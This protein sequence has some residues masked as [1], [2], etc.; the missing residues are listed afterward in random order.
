M[1]KALWI[2]LGFALSRSVRRRVRELARIN[3]LCGLEPRPRRPLPPWTNEEIEHL[4]GCAMFQAGLVIG[5]VATL[6]A[7]TLYAQ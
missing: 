4:R 7:M 6:L 2:G 1:R 3:A 5:G